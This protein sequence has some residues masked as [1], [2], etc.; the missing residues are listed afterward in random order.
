MTSARTR[1]TENMSTLLW[2]RARGRGVVGLGVP[3]GILGV[4]PA[5]VCLSDG[6]F[7]LEM[8]CSGCWWSEESCALIY[9]LT[10]FLA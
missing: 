7:K 1:Y 5:S 2:E 4:L 10:A 3:S 6:F 9:T 8:L